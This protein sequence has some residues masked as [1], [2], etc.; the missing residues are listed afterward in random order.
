MVI[1]GN[2]CNARSARADID[3]C[4]RG[5][6][7]VGVAPTIAQLAEIVLP[8]AFEI[9]VVENGT[10]VEGKRRHSNGRATRSEVDGCGWGASVLVFPPSP[11]CPW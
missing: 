4:G 9:T 6:I 1:S 5:C 2:E 10:G 7:G 8:P 11:N 3:G